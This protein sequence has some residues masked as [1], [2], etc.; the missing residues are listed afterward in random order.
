MLIILSLKPANGTERNGHC[1]ICRASILG[2]VKDHSVLLSIIFKKMVN[3]YRVA[4]F[5]F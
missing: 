2:A 4:F 5:E 3:N 1:T